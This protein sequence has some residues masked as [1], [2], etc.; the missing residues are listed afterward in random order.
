MDFT[1]EKV[2]SHAARRD[3]ARPIGLPRYA[4][5]ST[6]PSATRTTGKHKV[7]IR[8]MLDTY[9]G[10]NDGVPFTIP[11]KKG[12]VDTRADFDEEADPRLHRGHREAG[13]SQ[14]P[15]HRGPHGAAQHQSARHRAGAA[16]EVAHLPLARQP[17]AR[18]EL[19][20]IRVHEDA[21]ARGQGRFLRGPVLALREHESREHA[22]RGLHLWPGRWTSAAAAG[23]VAGPERT[24]VRAS[25]T[26]ISWSPP[27][28][29][30]PARATR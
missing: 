9:I 15:R 18:W 20:P 26:T 12:F 24:G 3:R 10:A 8:V 16:G 13:R 17:T 25:R 19:E 28:S 14:E 7:G 22:R 11:G 4:A 2:R 23:T 5:W 27:T 30:T 1:G 21:R 6:T 29:G